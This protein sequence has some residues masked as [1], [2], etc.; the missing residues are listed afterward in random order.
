MD[1]EKKVANEAARLMEA[2]GIV[3]PVFVTLLASMMLTG[4]QYRQVLLSWTEYNAAVYPWSVERWHSE[5]CRTLLRCGW[6]IGP[7]RFFT[8]LASG[9]QV[10]NAF[11]S[12]D[13]FT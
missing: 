1:E 13:V 8:I 4:S 6:E 3:S 10:D 7:E 9:G 2:H 11:R 12:P 5:L